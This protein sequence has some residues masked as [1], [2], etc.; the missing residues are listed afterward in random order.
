MNKKIIISS[1]L[2]L[3]IISTVSLADTVISSTL[4]ASGETTYTSTSTGSFGTFTESFNN[5]GTVSFKTAS[6]ATPEAFVTASKLN[7]FGTG[8]YSASTPPVIGSISPTW[9]SSSFKGLA[10]YKLP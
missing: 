8:S 9:S 4:S 1:I 7:G 2:F 6:L 5:V 3:S 10:I